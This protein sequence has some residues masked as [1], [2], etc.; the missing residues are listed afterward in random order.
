MMC[1]LFS[2]VSGYQL[3]FTL[4]RL[5][6]NI[7]HFARDVRQFSKPTSFPKTCCRDWTSEVSPSKGVTKVK[8]HLHKYAAPGDMIITTLGCRHPGEA[9]QAAATFVVIQSYFQ[10]KSN[11][12]KEF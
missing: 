2:T 4:W 12:Q 5:G 3:Q 11:F 6:T 10:H 9:L 7:L 8:L 1:I